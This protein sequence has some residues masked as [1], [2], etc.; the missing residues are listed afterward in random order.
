[1]GLCLTRCV[2]NLP[3]KKNDAGFLTFFLLDEKHPP[4]VT[5]GQKSVYSCAASYLSEIPNI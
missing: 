5:S 4:R 1:V 3:I 2:C